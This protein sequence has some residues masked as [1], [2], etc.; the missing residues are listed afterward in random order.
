MKLC[1]LHVAAIAFVLLSVSLICSSTGASL[2][3]LCGHG[4]SGLVAPPETDADARTAELGRRLFFEQRLSA[5]GSISCSTC[6]DPDRAFTD[7]KRYSVGIHQRMGT[8][9][10]PTLYNIAYTNH[11]LWDG[12][13]SSLEDQVIIALKN[14][15]EMGLTESRLDK[16]LDSYHS[17]FLAV[18]G[19]PPTLQKVASAIAAFERTL[20]IGDSPVDRFLY[21][22]ATDALSDIQKKGLEL[23]SG[24][25]NCIR[26]HWY[27]HESVHPLG[28][29]QALFTDNRFHNIGAGEFN[30]PGRAAITGSAE[31]WGAFKTPTLRNVTLTAPYMHDGSLATLREVV[32]FYNRG[33]VMN[34]GDPNIRPL[35]LSV[36]DIDA[37]VEFLRA[38]TSPAAKQRR[39]EW[40]PRSGTSHSGS[41]FAK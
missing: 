8:R 40:Q 34:S 16:R 15:N 17:E 9:N 36:A 13:A 25:A 19:E 5:N 6:H 23:F 27:S 39:E 35:R 33:G 31:D 21:C 26:C 41:Q 24:P 1:R 18:F 22:G 37:I 11:F 20:L 14:P 38:L 4:I 7:G 12:R 3:E 29:R 32:E 28:G 2:E 30:D 10:S